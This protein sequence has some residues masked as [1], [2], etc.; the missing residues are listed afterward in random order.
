MTALSEMT[1]VELIELK[2]QIDTISTKINDIIGYNM[3][4]AK[5]SKLHAAVVSKATSPSGFVSVT[6]ETRQLLLVAGEEGTT[7]EGIVHILSK[8]RETNAHAV[9]TALRRMRIMGQ[10][11]N[12]RR[13]WYLKD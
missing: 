10:A 4:S 12:I 11:Y 2:A 1:I 6:Q 9:R 5:R 3:L 7:V 13:R 8:R